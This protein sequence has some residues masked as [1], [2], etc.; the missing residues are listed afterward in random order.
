M[1]ERAS[2]VDPHVVGQGCASLGQVLHDEYLGE[3]YSALL[4]LRCFVSNEILVL[5]RV[6]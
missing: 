3:R 1:V 5:D 6:V 2:L 4:W